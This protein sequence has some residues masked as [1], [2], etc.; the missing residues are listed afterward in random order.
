MN[1]T[2]NLGLFLLAIWLLLTGLIDVFGL[3]FA[4]LDLI[5]ALLALVAG[6]VLLLQGL[7]VIKRLGTKRKWGLILLSIWL[8]L[9][10]LF[11]LIS[12]SFEGQALA[13]G[14]LALAAGVLVLIDR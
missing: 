12:L 5:M 11:S 6:I 4:N 2:R 14:V 8:I 3:S 13:M 7:N 10:A 1:I 9:M